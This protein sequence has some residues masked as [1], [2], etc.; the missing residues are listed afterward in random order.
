MLNLY[1]FIEVFSFLKQVVGVDDRILR[2]G[3]AIS[4]VCMG[5]CYWKWG[6]RHNRS[7]N[8][9]RTIEEKCGTN[10]TK[11]LNETNRNLRNHF[12]LF[13]EYLKTIHKKSRGMNKD[14]RDKFEPFLQEY[15][16][17]IEKGNEKNR[18]HRKRLESEA[19]CETNQC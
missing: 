7:S 6:I 17:I 14:L 18:N 1:T 4:M 13:L 3:M 12:E 8:R 16:L 2:I 5:C 19:L 15:H 11:T 10:E 9:K